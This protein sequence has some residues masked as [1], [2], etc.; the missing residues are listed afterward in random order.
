M[1][2]NYTVGQY[3]GKTASLNVA[4]AGS[5]VLHSFAVWAGY[6]EHTRIGNKVIIRSLLNWLT[7]MWIIVIYQIFDSFI[8]RIHNFI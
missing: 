2:I 7:L 3:T 4:C 8:L 6:Q 1:I 5:I